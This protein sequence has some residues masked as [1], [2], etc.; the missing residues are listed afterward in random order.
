M[1]T[2]KAMG[3]QKRRFLRR[4]QRYLIHLLSDLVIRAYVR[5][6]GLGTRRGKRAIGVDDLEDPRD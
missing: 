4:R 5:Q 1:A 2:A 6:E 3:E